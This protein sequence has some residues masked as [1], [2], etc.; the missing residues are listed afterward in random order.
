[1]IETYRTELS[2]GLRVVVHP[3]RNTAMVALDVLYNVG[4][5]DESP[6]LTGMAHLFEHLMFGGSANVADFDK[7]V[8]DAG[9]V[10]N[11]WTSNDFTNFYTIVPAVNAETA[12][13]VESDRM[14]APLLT[15]RVL[16]VQRDV[17]VEEF[18]QTCLNT[19]YGDMMHHLR[20]LAY[21][22]HPYRWPTLGLTPDHVASVTDG[23]VTDFFNR[24]YSP[25][26]AVIAVSGNIV[27]ERAFELAERYFGSIPRRRVARRGYKPEAP[28]TAPLSATV[29]GNVP[30]PRIVMAFPMAAYGRPGYVEADIITDIL[31]NGQASRFMR[32]IVMRGDVVTSADASI[33]GSDEPGL[34]L[35]SASVRDST[36]GAVER[37]RRLL[38]E[39]LDRIAS[40]EPDAGE[41]SRCQARFASLMAFGQ[42]SF[43]TCAEEL[44][45]AEM[46][47]EDINTRAD[48][49]RAVTGDAIMSEASRIL[50]PDNCATLLYCPDGMI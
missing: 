16:E 44:A 48:R 30:H 17:V 37:A 21:S 45:Q 5:R 11:A 40:S 25:D 19:P 31:A 9:G 15:G 2:N 6:G 27:P 47:G 12:F 49:Y 24:H 29:T 32:D 36:C 7:A 46:Q 8:E 3:D 33:I 23:D 41:L 13:W 38:W 43:M 39:Q 42:M 10:N 26:N 1:M 22:S 35:V 50:R 34:L 14:L 4:S 20:A 18:K 28:F